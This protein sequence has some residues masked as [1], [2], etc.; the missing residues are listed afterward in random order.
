ML[1]PKTQDLGLLTGTPCWPPRVKIWPRCLV[2]FVPRASRGNVWASRGH[3]GSNNGQLVTAQTFAFTYWCADHGR[4]G[5]LH[6][7]FLGFNSETCTMAL[8]L[9]TLNCAKMDAEGP[10]YALLCENQWKGGCMWETVNSLGAMVSYMRPFWAIHY[11][12]HCSVRTVQ[13]NSIL[14]LVLQKTRDKAYLSWSLN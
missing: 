4:R 1:T 8:V 11:A 2:K 12:M 13:H 6:L 5:C 7:K 14:P 10:Q 3:P 9:H